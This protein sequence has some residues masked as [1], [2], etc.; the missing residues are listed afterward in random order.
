[1]KGCFYHL[2]SNVW[3]KVKELGFQQRYVNDEEFAIHCRMICAL[4][5]L[6]EADV[7]DGF[8]ELTDAIQENFEDD[9]DGLLTYFEV[10]YIDWVRRN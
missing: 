2:S 9:F 1:M 3:K 8:G 5:F 10:T 6:P 7:I 4:A